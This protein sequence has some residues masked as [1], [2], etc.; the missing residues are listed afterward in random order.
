MA[1]AGLHGII[2]VYGA[3]LCGSRG[4]LGT[5]WR[6]GFRF[7]L[8]LGSL[9]PDADFFLLGPLFLYDSRLALT[10]H[11]SFTHSILTIAALTIL[12]Y[13]IAR[14]PRGKGLAW[15][16]G[17]GMLLHSLVDVFIWFSGVELFWP[18]GGVNL[19]AGVH[20]PGWVSNLLGTADYLAF[21]LYYLYLRGL[22]RGAGRR[23]DASWLNRWIVLQWLAF[24][25]FLL[26]TWFLPPDV[27]NIAHYALFIL[28]FFPLALC[29]TVKMRPCI[30]GV[31]RPPIPHTTAG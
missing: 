6:A 20:N 15:G 5:K 9:L 7:G 13:A 2:G 27:F 11:R 30:E 12:L 24:V 18:L 16:L 1:Q 23:P 10:M 26:L 17:L 4:A 14:G 21:A 22:A 29:I 31:R 25:A 19:W 8:V 28:F 3:S